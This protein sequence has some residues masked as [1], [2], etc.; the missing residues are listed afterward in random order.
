[1]PQRHLSR[2]ALHEG[3]QLVHLR[4]GEVV[5]YK[6]PESDIWQARFK[7]FDRK[8]RRVSTKYANIEYAIRAACEAYDEA[9]FRER[10]GLPIATRSFAS[11]AKMAV[12]ELKQ[13]IAA[14]TGKSIYK[15]YITVIEKY[16]LPYFAT[17]K[18]TSIDYE[19]VQKFEQWRNERMRKTPKASTLLNHAAAF[20]RVVELAVKRGWLSSN[21]T[22]PRLS[23]KG[24]RSGARPAFNRVEI[25]FLLTYLVDWVKG[26]SIGR[27]ND[28]RVALRD[29][30]EVLLFTGMRHGTEAMNIQWKHLEWHIDGDSKRYL[31]I[32]VSGKTGPRWLISRH[33][34][35][36][37]IERIRQRTPVLAEL[38][39][40]QVLAQ[41]RDEW[42]FALPSGDRPYNYVHAFR[43]LM[44]AYGLEKD[45]SGKLNRT[46]YS[47]RHT[48]ATF[49]LVEGGMDIHTLAKQMGTSIQMIEQHYSKLT[50]TM[51]AAKLAG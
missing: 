30:I 7:L 35:L 47:L 10:L 37:A 25:D 48:Y 44:R 19:A 34:V 28:M 1:M 45:T 29:Y 5:L 39:L 4:D 31:R 42:L 26:G 17:A 2:L 33:Q 51:N 40:D 14:G 50:P 36:T 8:W 12:V 23:T 16:L 15:D 20:N 32:W 27:G 49:S 38:T 9:R 41:K 18:L 13:E 11:V 22:I 43:R 6:R 3:Q 46:L 21:H 24:E